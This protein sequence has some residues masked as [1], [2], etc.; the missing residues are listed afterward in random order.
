MKIGVE[1]GK[2][3]SV[4]KRLPDPPPLPLDLP[5]L[6]EAEK[7]AEVPRIKLFPGKYLSPCI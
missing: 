5:P 1:A 4:G 6:S 2:A 7:N 3:V